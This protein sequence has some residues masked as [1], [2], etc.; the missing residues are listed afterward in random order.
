MQN[1]N[2]KSTIVSNIHRRL[3]TVGFSQ[4][5]LGIGVILLAIITSWV[6]VKTLGMILIIWAAL[7]IIPVLRFRGNNEISHIVWG[8]I[9]AGIGILL[10]FSPGI[11]AAVI[12][13]M[14]AALFVIG[15]VYN[16][17]VVSRDQPNR[18]W[19]RAGS[20]VSILLG[21]FIIAR[22]PLTNFIV[23]GTLIGIEI[24]LNG[25]SIAAIEYAGKRVKT[26]KTV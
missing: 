9:I 7:E 11:G 22:W 15:G 24:L 23:L 19:S 26:T 4:I 5:V 8:C 16:M 6:S 25:W 1:V 10:L 14:L 12:S 13:L 17:I 18:G 20:V 2:S 3:K 21:L